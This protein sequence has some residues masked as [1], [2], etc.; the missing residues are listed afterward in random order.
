M[1]HL[2]PLVKMGMLN[3]WGS[4]HKQRAAIK[5][6]LKDNFI[7]KRG[8]EMIK[9]LNRVLYRSYL[10]KYG[11]SIGQPD[12]YYTITEDQSSFLYTFHMMK[13]LKKGVQ[14]EC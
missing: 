12:E 5:E 13:L 10:K 1:A 4:G 14:Y 7:N 9:T 6:S 3:T 8:V 11:L 2:F